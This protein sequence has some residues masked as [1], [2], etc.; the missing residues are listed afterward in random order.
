MQICDCLGAFRLLRIQVRVRLL[1]WFRLLNSRISLVTS[2]VHL[3]YSMGSTGTCWCMYSMYILYLYF[4]IL[5]LVHIVL[6]PINIHR[7]NCKYCTCTVQYILT[8]LE[9]HSLALILALVLTLIHTLILTHARTSS[10]FHN[11]VNSILV[12]LFDLQYSTA[13][14]SRRTSVHESNNQTRNMCRL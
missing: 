8:C 5:T 9:E 12:S 10:E 1:D 3:Q 14:V 13:T 6:L 2:T 7:V 4:D 11:V